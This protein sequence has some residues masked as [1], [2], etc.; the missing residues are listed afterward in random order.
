VRV[1]SDR[2]HRPSNNG[3]RPLVY[4]KV[5]LINPPIDHEGD[6][7]GRLDGK[8]ALITGAGQGIGLGIA[9]ALASEGPAFRSRS[10]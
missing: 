8:V 5:C 6:R 4:V 1:V 10:W 3:A 7:M 2:V 9:L